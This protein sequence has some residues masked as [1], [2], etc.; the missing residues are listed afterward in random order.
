VIIA[1]TS[2]A[3]KAALYARLMAKSFEKFVC[4]S[5]PQFWC[6]VELAHYPWFAGS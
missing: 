5:F 1:A 6:H 3:E 2:A 4:P